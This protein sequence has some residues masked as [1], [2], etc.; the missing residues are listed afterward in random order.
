M[1]DFTYYNPVKIIFGQNSLEKLP[2]QLSPNNRILLLYGQGSI[3]RNGI[4]QKIITLL[5]NHTFVEFAGITPNPHLEDCLQAIRTIKENDL[6]FI[7]AVG[8]G[9]VIDAAKFIAAGVK[10]DGDPW[11]ILSRHAPILSALPLGSVLTLPAT[12]SEMNCNFVITNDAL[13]IKLAS[14]SPLVYPQFSILDPQTSYS[15]DQRQTANGIADSFVHV[16]EQYLTYP[17]NTPLQDRQAEAVLHTLICEGKK[18]LTSPN[19]YQTRANIMW[20]ATHA[21]NNIIGCGVPQDWTTH[22]IGHELTALY[23]IDHAQS[24]VIVLPR[25]M[26]YK[27][28][29]KREKIIQYGQRLWNKEIPQE[30]INTTE[31]FFASLGMKTRL[32]QYG[33]DANQAAQ[34]VSARLEQRNIVM[35]ERRDIYPKDVLEIVSAC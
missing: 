26:Q 15:L 4:Y 18:V 23:G 30:I 8:G 29:Q 22:A 31:D 34:R 11:Q 19:D 3:K 9:S 27:L 21:L 10:F 20:A 13:K 35:G 28:E 16:M 32:E 33:I 5:G 12:G 25:I 7:L 17:T 6:N 24:L 2:K 14:A 1:K